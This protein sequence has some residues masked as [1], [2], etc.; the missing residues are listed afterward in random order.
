VE[1]HPINGPYIPWI[2]YTQRL[3]K[4]FGLM[5]WA[6]LRM[7]EPDF[8]PEFMTAAVRVALKVEGRVVR[9]AVGECKQGSKKMTQFDCLEGAM[10][11]GLKRCCSDLGMFAELHDRRWREQWLVSHAR[12]TKKDGYD[13]WER[14]EGA[15]GKSSPLPPAAD[16]L[17]EGIVKK[18]KVLDAA[19]K[20]YLVTVESEMGSVDVVAKEP[21]AKYA[22]PTLLV[23]TWVQYRV[24][25]VPVRGGGQMTVFDHFAVLGQP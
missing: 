3:N 25:Q 23:D 5:G 12:K 19:T 9:D 16:L 13:Q 10:K 14:V 2:K 15:A 4:A 24:K 20:K 21:I 17:T 22:D 18:V 11:N 6:R 1:L 7:G 8:D